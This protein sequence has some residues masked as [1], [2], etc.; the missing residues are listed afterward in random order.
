LSVAIAFLGFALVLHASYPGYL[1]PDSVVHLVQIERGIFDDWHSPFVKLIMSGLVHRVHG[2]FGFVVVTNLL[3]WGAALALALGMRQLIGAWSVLLAMLPLFPGAFNFLGNVHVD[4]LLAAWLL[5]AASAAWL[6]YRH[7]VSARGRKVLQLMA[8]LFI[9]AAF[10][11]RVNAIF[12]VIPLLLYANARLGTRRNVLL[13][14]AM[15]VAMPVLN[16]VQKQLLHVVPSSVADSIKVYNLLAMSY[17]ER[18]NL[19]PG[20]WSA[21]HSQAIVNACYSPVQ[22]DTAGAEGQCGFIFTELQRQQLWGSAELTKAWLHAITRHPA[23]YFSALAATFRKSMFDPNS[24]SM[25]YQSPNPWG[26]KVADDP[27]RASTELVHAYVH[28]EFNDRVGRPWIYALIS[29]FGVILLFRS[30]AVAS[31]AGHFALAVLASGLIYLLT[32]F[33]FNVSAEYRYFYWCGFAA[34]TGVIATLAAIVARR[35]DRPQTAKSAPL[36]RA[37]SLLLVSLAVA[38]LVFPCRLPTGWRAITITPLDAEPVIVTGVHNAATPKWM[39]QVF[40]GNI[41]PTHWVREGAAYRSTL[42]GS[43]L[44]VEMKTLKQNIDVVLSTGPGLG[45]VSIEETGLRQRVDTAA[46]RSGSLT[47][48]LLPQ[49]A[50]A[51]ARLSYLWKN[52]AGALLSFLVLLALFWKLGFSPAARKAGGQ[53]AAVR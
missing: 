33:V 47:I 15:L 43:P 9:V 1:N 32:Y 6:S 30:G 39:G 7:G 38:L 28:S 52:F 16:G 24:R 26:W 4:A 45:S 19:F 2:A 37:S 3:I 41:N 18:K 50:P 34:Y 17:H 23:S 35:R 36:L 21:P 14:I 20:E 49:I 51:H 11:T 42:A 40:Q 8:N 27:P 46:E 22:W 12:A 10:L 5:A 44:I 53:R 31:E 48:S 25:L 13:C 29:A